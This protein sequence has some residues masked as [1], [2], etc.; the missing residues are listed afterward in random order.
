MTQA[1]PH[2][3]YHRVSYRAWNG[4]WVAGEWE[5]GPLQDWNSRSTQE[6]VASAQLGVMAQGMHGYL[7]GLCEPS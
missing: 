2:L 5:E 1:Q 4:S 3:T 7:A 6:A